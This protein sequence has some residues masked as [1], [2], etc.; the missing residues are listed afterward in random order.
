[1]AAHELEM[2]MQIM[3]V[4]PPGAPQPLMQPPPGMLIMQQQQQSS[5][6]N[7]LPS[8]T[9]Q[10]PPSLPSALQQSWSVDLSSL[11]ES[12]DLPSLMGARIDRP[13]DEPPANDDPEK[14]PEVLVLPKALEDVFAFKDQLADELGRTDG[15]IP[16]DA[17]PSF[18]DGRLD[19]LG[20]I[21]AAG[22]ISGNIFLFISRLFF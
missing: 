8:T 21:R 4:P 3:S 5:G 6:I 10:P 7:Q 19:G 15:E 14:S 18:I 12:N 22:V 16:F 13:D 9:L 17:M 1:M 2:Q 20:A 11:D